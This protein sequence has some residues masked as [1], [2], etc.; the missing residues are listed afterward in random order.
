ML[1]G[2]DHY[3][4]K[5]RTLLAEEPPTEP[6]ARA[7]HTLAAAIMAFAEKPQEGPTDVPLA[8]KVHSAAAIAL[9]PA[10]EDF[11]YDDCGF[12]SPPPRETVAA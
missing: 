8:A 2:F 10:E 9:D 11:P 5:A 1:T 7:Q 4:N 6:L 3:A 12:P